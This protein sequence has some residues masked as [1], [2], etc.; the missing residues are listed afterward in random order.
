MRALHIRGPC[1]SG[2]GTVLAK[3]SRCRLEVALSSVPSWYV[4]SAPGWMKLGDNHARFRNH[5]CR[6]S[7]GARVPE[8][9]LGAAAGRWTS[10][11]CV[12]HR[13]PIVDG[14]PVFLL[15]EKQQT[16]GI[17][18]ASLKAAED[19]TGGPLYIETLGLSDDEK[20]SIERE[21]AA[22][23]TIDSV[24]S[25][26]VGATSGW[27]CRLDWPA[28]ELSHPGHPGGTRQR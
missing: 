27:L 12:G 20:R 15:A 2:P 14:I 28:T 16:I 6:A 1:P 25:H 22:G 3:W 11:L 5:R 17:A 24:I 7:R 23:Q 9:Q 8:R 18:S 13:Y 26:L 4:P 21:C 19:A 10:A